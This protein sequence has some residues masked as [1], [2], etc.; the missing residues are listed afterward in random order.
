MICISDIKDVLETFDY[1]GYMAA[2]HNIGPYS[3]AATYMESFLS[4]DLSLVQIEAI[5]WHGLYREACVCHNALTN[6]PY[7]IPTTDAMFIV[8]ESERFR[9]AAIKLRKLMF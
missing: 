9:D 3:V 6:K 1:F 4:P 2:G 5:I 7:I 8:G